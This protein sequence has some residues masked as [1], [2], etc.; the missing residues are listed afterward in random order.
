IV[1]LQR[2][3]ELEAILSPIRR[4]T[5]CKVHTPA[6]AS[7]IGSKSSS[8]RVQRRAMRFAAYFQNAQQRTYTFEEV[9]L[10]GTWMAG[11]APLASHL[12]KYLKETRSRYARVYSAEICG[13][14]LGLMVSQPIQSH[15]PELGV[16]LEQL[17][18]REFTLTVA[19]RLKHLLVGL[20]GGNGKL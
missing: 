7:V 15:A 9:A 18:A 1:A 6:V 14:H 4:R 11:G 12:L 19:P 5:D 10:I 17:K 20:E 8:Y 16:A 3:G 2:N 13:R